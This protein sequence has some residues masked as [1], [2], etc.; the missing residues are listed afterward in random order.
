LRKGRAII[1]SGPSG[2]GK[3]TVIAKWM[4]RNNSL[5]R[6]CTY[7]TR[8]PREGERNG[9]DYN[10]VTRD[11]FENLAN[12]GHFLEWKEVHGHFYASPLNDTLKLIDEGLFPI[13]KIDVQGAIAA[14][15]KLKNAITIFILPPTMEELERRIRQRHSDTE[16]AIRLRLKNAIAE[17]EQ[18]DK[19]EYRVVNANLERCIDELEEIL[20]RES[21]D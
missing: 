5:R 1:L 6:I 21:K 2:V 10:F 4:L 7:T 20:E 18:K 13:L 15:P 14:M 16:D 11:E 19:Y 9:V 3:D 8:D 12:E 17:I